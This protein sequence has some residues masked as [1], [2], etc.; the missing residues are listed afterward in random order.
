MIYSI[1]IFLWIKFLLFAFF[2]LFSFVEASLKHKKQ[3]LWLKK[4]EF[5]C[6]RCARLYAA[7]KNIEDASIYLKSQQLLRPQK[8]EKKKYYLIQ[9]VDQALAKFHCLEQKKNQVFK[10]IVTK[11][12]NLSYHKNWPNWVGKVLK[13][14]D[15]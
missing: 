10:I 9:K 11:Q 13:K 4:Q 8:L 3:L 1:F 14:G 5:L 6:M 12:K 15:L 2:N 7:K